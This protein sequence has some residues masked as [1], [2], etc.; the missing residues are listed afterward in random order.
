MTPT[1]PQRLGLRPARL[2]HEAQRRLR[3][4]RA[5]ALL[6][7]VQPSLALAAAAASGTVARA[8][9]V[10][11]A[12]SYVLGAI[13]LLAYE[14]LSTA[15][16]SAAAAAGALVISTFV[17]A[18]PHGELYLLLHVGLVFY[19][20]FHFSARRAIAIVLLLVVLASAAAVQT[21]DGWRGAAE[22]ALINTGALLGAAA[23]TL[24]LRRR[25]V[26][27]L[28]RARRTNETL[29]AFFLHAS[30]GFAFLDRDL[31]HV[32]VNEPLARMLHVP[33]EQLVGST[34]GELAP[35][36]AATLEPLL[37]RVLETGKPLEGL[38]VASPDGKR[39]YLVSYYAIHGPDGSL[40]LG[41]TV[42]D[43]THLKD[44]ER[45]LEETNRRLTVLATTDELTG[46]PNRRMLGDQLELAL[47][48]ARRG[49]LAVSVLYLDVDGFKEVNDSYGHAYGDELLV[50]IAG[51]L[52]AGARDTDVVARVGGD[53][54][55]V[56]LSDLEVQ[57]A[58][59]L[60][61]AVAERIR[62]ELELPL[63]VG[64][65]ELKVAASIGIATYP[66]DARDANGLL[67]AADAAMYAGKG[68]LTRVA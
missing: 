34:I 4:A 54:F 62:A 10:A 37:H 60:A 55:L 41:E 48:R 25:L 57:A 51:R 16:K 65:L 45:R 31:R 53:E 15:A 8:G 40:G 24:S 23:I 6:F 64:I 14:H 67:A 52:R 2:D 27:A 12:V 3:S 44:V 11:A 50:A 18:Q 42:V 35:H 47:A 29:D 5:A 7:A 66:L 38:E 46:L 19:V 26:A 58:P 22:V 56:L 21:A 30:T 43:V 36:L 68:A 39:H 61:A 17:L 20:A 28:V 49:G 1:I 63:T 59:E 32:R 33:A 9:I 13:V